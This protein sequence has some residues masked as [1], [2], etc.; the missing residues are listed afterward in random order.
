MVERFSFHPYGRDDIYKMLMASCRVEVELRHRTF[1]PLTTYTEHVYEVAAW[2]SQDERPTFGLYLCGNRGNGKTTLVKAIKSLY[3]F[4]DDSVAMQSTDGKFPRPGFEIVTS[5]ELVRLTKAYLNP[6]RD[7]ADDVYRYKRLRD[8]QVLAIDDLG[9]E[10]R[11]SMNYG[12]FVTAAIDMLSYRYD[13]QLCTIAT[14]NLAPPEIKRH[15][16]ERFADRFREMM[17]IVNFG[18]DE[19]FR[20]RSPAYEKV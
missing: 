9:T 1:L 18:D 14:S 6:T 8:I 4:L 15:Y 16:D 3:Q 19:S 2:L 12:D 5:K 11:E 20:E 13:Y 10:P 7:N 17:H